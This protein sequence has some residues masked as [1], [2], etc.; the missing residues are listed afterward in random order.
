MDMA[1]VPYQVR[2]DA[3]LLERLRA[4]A[5]S[6]GVTVTALLERG[7]RAV[8]GEAVRPVPAVRRV[9]PTRRAPDS[10]PVPERV[11]EP[12]SAAAPVC[13]RCGHQESQH[14]ARGCL[15]GCVCRRFREGGTMDRY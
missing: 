15:A 6:E 4:Q 12:V 7:A 3:G 1:K 14:W 10:R 5:E 9:P 11:P 13:A 2:L 8:L